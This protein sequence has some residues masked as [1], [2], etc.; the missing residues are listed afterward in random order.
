ML[1]SWSTF[2]VLM[3]GRLFKNVTG[4]YIS[5]YVEFHTYITYVCSIYTHVCSVGDLTSPSLCLSIYAEIN[6][7]VSSPPPPPPPVRSSYIEA[8]ATRHSAQAH[9]ERR[10]ATVGR[11][12]AYT[13]RLSVRGSRVVEVSRLESRF[14]AWT[15]DH[16]G[17]LQILDYHTIAYHT[18]Y[19]GPHTQRLLF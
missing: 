3:S 9:R 11:R 17:T 12:I 19:T 18:N 15:I 16:A 10:T 6:R 8:L 7:T 5:V 1:K 14:A 13:Y 4:L 2:I